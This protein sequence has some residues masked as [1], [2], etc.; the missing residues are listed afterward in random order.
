MAGRQVTIDLAGDPP[1]LVSTV[2][3]SAMLR[4]AITGDADP[5]AQNRFTAL[6][7]FQILACDATVADCSHDA[8]YHGVFTSAAGR[9]P[10]RRRSGRWRR[11]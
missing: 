7:S 9:V 8:G 4:P 5:G 6:R 1:Q 2:N 10:R 3:V 11:S